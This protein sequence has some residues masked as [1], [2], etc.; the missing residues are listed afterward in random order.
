MMSRPQPLRERPTRDGKTRLVAARVATGMPSRR[1]GYRASEVVG[2]LGLEGTLRY[3][4]LA[5]FERVIKNINAAHAVPRT[6]GEDGRGW[7]TYGLTDIARLVVL[8]DLCGGTDAFAENGSPRLR[9]LH[10]VQAAALALRER[11]GYDDPLLE[12]PL[13]RVGRTVLA[14]IDGQLIEPG[15]GQVAASFS[16][17]PEKGD[18]MAAVRTSNPALANGL[19]AS[20]RRAGKSHRK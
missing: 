20:I 7:R 1:R 14:L 17:A 6:G 2:A 12:V 11:R 4:R 13:V 16:L 18:I 10:A 8:I 9:G 15:T 3:D 19:T 5:S